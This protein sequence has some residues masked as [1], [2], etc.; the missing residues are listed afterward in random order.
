MTAIEWTDE[1]FNPWQGCTKVSPGC[2]NCYAATLAKRNLHGNGPV[3]WGNGQTRVRN[4]QEYWLKP[5]SWDRKA[6]KA[7]KRT[8]VFAASMG[9]I[10]DPE[11]EPKWREDFWN[12]VRQTPNLDWQVLTKRPENIS[13]MLPQG[14][15]EGWENVW[16]GT[17]VEDQTRAEKRIPLL[18]NI[19]AKVRFLSVEPLIGPVLFSDLS[20]IHWVICGGESGKSYRTLKPEW[21]L[22]VRDQCI[23]AN[24]PF[25]F[26]QWGTANKKFA[27][28]LLDGKIWDEFPLT[29]HESGLRF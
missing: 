14:W 12:L 6:G 11:V 7:G 15:G 18:S 16:L 3:L 4:S 10:F 29:S 28:R 23:Q 13:G 9:D 27:G 8:K 21:A 22:S 1:T 24:V 19:P 2:L 17:S 26:K 20:K 5:L 25:F